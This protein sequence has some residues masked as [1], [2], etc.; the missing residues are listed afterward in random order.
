MTFVI[1][2]AF[3]VAYDFAR[4]ARRTGA[5]VR[6]WKTAVFGPSI[7]M[8]ARRSAGQAQWAE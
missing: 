4:D 1:A 3:V 5:A 8:P 2:L 6:S 7:R